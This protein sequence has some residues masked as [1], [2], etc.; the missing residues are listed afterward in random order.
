MGI[1]RRREGGYQARTRDNKAP[2]S[3]GVVCSLEGENLDADYSA[4]LD[5]EL[6]M[7]NAE[8]SSLGKEPITS[9][10]GSSA[11]RFDYSAERTVKVFGR[12]PA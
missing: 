1:A 12:Q 4:R 3:F 8:R 6:E 9:E 10:R 11:V 5:L 7:L 2:I